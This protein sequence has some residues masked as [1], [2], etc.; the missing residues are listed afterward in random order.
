MRITNPNPHFQPRILHL[1][2]LGIHDINVVVLVEEDAARAA[3][4][5]QLREEGVGTIAHE[6]AAALVDGYGVEHAE[7]T[8]GGAGFAPGLD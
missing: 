8:G 3:I 1:V 4:L 6:D 5:G 7:F 2:R